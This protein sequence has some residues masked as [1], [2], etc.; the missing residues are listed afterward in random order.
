MQVPGGSALDTGPGV[1]EANLKK[2]C[3]HFFTTRSER[4]TKAWGLSIVQRVVEERG[5]R[6]TIDSKLGRG[7]EGRIVFPAT[8]EQLHIA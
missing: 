5:S 4:A 6:V 2:V 8:R 1:A 3:E 7:S